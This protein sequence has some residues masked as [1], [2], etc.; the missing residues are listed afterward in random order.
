MID[1]GRVENGEG[2]WDE[3][4]EKGVERGGY[5]RIGILGE[6]VEERD[7]GTGAETREK[8]ENGEE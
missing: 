8:K 4:R 1:T 7:E 2:G 3:R 5:S 6:K